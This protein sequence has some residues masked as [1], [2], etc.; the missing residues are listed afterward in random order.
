M[1]MRRT[2]NRLREGAGDVVCSVIRAFHYRS[3][4]AALLPRL[5]HTARRAVP[6]V[7][8]RGQILIVA[9]W[10]PDVARRGQIL[11]VAPQV[12]DVAPWGQILIV[13]PWV[14]DVAPWGQ[15]LIVA[16]RVPDVAR[17]GQILMLRRRCQTLRRCRSHRHTAKVRG[18]RQ[19][20]LLAV[21]VPASRAFIPFQ[22]TARSFA[23]SVCACE[24]SLRCSRSS[25]P[26]FLRQ[27][28]RN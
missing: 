8:P 7:A 1:R 25:L 22:L 28:L 26:R 20:R 24:A 3:R 17:R 2:A 16:P 6:N 14:P 12:P 19:R 10:V 18:P 27:P 13:A 23:A 11:I 9:P 5:D 4:A 21:L 15:I